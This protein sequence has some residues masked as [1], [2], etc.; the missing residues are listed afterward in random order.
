M[1]ITSGSGTRHIDFREYAIQPNTFFLLTPGQVHFWDVQGAIDGYVLL[2][3]EEFLT[4][5]P[6]DEGFLRNLDFFHRVDYDP[7]IYL[8]GTEVQSIQATIENLTAEYEQEQPGRT[9]AIQSLLRLLLIQLQ[10]HY[11]VPET[12]NVPSADLMLIDRFQRLIDQHYLTRR[13]VGE[14]ADLLGIT[15]GYLTKISRDVTGLPAGALIRNRIIIEAKRLLAH[16]DNT[17]AEICFELQFED[18]SYFGRFFKR[19]TGQS[20]LSFRQGFRKKYQTSPN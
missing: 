19:E 7:V 12:P 1:W 6:P 10:R 4:S 2:F 14:Y 11:R 8:D 3:L 18:P 9:L 16:T 15:P 20:P 13:S 5:G 17:V